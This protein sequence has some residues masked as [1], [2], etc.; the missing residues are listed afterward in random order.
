[1]NS[2]VAGASG[3]EKVSATHKISPM[4]LRREIIP[5]EAF[6]THLEDSAVHSAFHWGTSGKLCLDAGCQQGCPAYKHRTKGTRK[7]FALSTQF[8]SS[9]KIADRFFSNVSPAPMQSLVTAS[10]KS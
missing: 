2:A 6:W 3:Q 1:M 9:A 4:P 5:R 7:Y 8:L 10:T